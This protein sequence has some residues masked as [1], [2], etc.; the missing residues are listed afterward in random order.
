VKISWPTF[1]ID[2]VL[3]FWFLALDFCFLFLGSCFL[4]LDFCFLIFFVS[5]T[6]EYAWCFTCVALF[7]CSSCLCSKQRRQSCTS[8]LVAA[9]HFTNYSRLNIIQDRNSKITHFVIFGFISD[10]KNLKIKT[11]RITYVTKHRSYLYVH[12]ELSALI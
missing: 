9:L 12:F 1:N 8:A 2:W 5:P 4:V 11:P 7:G 10:A 6:A 3:V